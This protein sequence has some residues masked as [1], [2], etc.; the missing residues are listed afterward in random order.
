MSARRLLVISILAGWVLTGFGTLPLSAQ[1]REFPAMAAPAQPSAPSDVMPTYPSTSSPAASYPSTSYR[2]AASA[3]GPTLGPPA[4]SPYDQLLIGTNS[5][6][7]DITGSMTVPP[8]AAAPVPFGS[9]YGK[10]DESLGS[11]P[12]D[13]N[14]FIERNL[15]GDDCWSWQ[16]MP[17]GIMYK[18]GLAN[19]RQPR[20]SVQMVHERNIGWFWEPTL[21][22]RA[23]I[24]RYG[25]DNEFW[26]QGWQVDIEGAAYA[27]LDDGRNM[28]STDFGFGIPLTMRQGPWEMKFGYNHLSS[29]LGDLF[30]LANPGY[31][32]INYVRES[33]VLGLA[34][35]VTPILRI[36]EENGWAFHVDGGAEP[37]EFRFGADFCTLEPTGTS[38]APFCSICA[39]LRQENDFGGNIDVQTGWLWRARTGHTFR[40][41]M[42]YFNGMSEQAQFYKKF[43]EQIGVG[44]WY[45]F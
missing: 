12:V 15:A 40:M 11:Q 32:R 29:H 8:T 24:L 3:T 34:Y 23:G 20:M 26:P 4:Q 43:E 17:N 16:I 21:G 1:V 25:T 22:G 2:S 10:A 19:Q 35:Y 37:W 6:S 39:H 33:L 14:T 27:R 44:A 41:G 36:Y 31:P 7:Q 9:P 38:G 30:M 13:V 18:P 5:P 42:Q 28:V 45:D